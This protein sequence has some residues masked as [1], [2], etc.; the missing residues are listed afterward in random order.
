M[1]ENRSNQEAKDLVSQM[2]S[3]RLLGPERER[4]L[5]NQIIE[6]RN[7]IRKHTSLELS[8][9]RLSTKGKYRNLRISAEQQL[10]ELRDRFFY[11]NVR[12]IIDV[13]NQMSRMEEEDMFQY[14]AIGLMRAIDLFDPNRG[15]AFSTYANF[16]IRQSIQRGCDR[17]ESLIAIPVHVR[18]MMKSLKKHGRKF[19]AEFGREPELKELCEYAKMNYEKVRNVLKMTETPTSLDH[20]RSAGDG[21]SLSIIEM[22]A[23]P[24]EPVVE[25]IIETLD[26]EFIRN[27]VR[28]AIELMEQEKNEHGDLILLNSARVLRLRFRV[29]EDGPLST[30]QSATRRLEDIG[31]VMGIKRD[32]VHQ[33]QKLGVQWII[34]NIDLR[35]EHVVES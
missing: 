1:F 6:T 35:E 11:A 32:K 25:R 34:E 19:I 16:W 29:G 10:T 33:L 31:K 26:R 24:T 4:E 27:K 12:L 17:D 15:S 30:K 8:S 9:K 13:V 7:L 22:V 20:L 21:D 14:G 23:D 5:A 2:A 3:T 18:D 28:D